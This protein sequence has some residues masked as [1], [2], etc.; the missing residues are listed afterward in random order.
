MRVWLGLLP[1][2]IA[3]TVAEPLDGFSG[4]SA[5]SG[6]I[7]VAV[8]GSGGTS[9]TGGFATAGSSGFPAIECKTASECS[10]G[11]PCNGAEVC[12]PEGKCGPG[13]APKLDDGNAC[14]V[15]FCDPKKG[16]VHEGS[17]GP[18]VKACG[19]PCPK[20]YYVSTA[21][22]CD[23]VCGG[24]ANCGFCVNGWACDEICLPTIQVC[25]RNDACNTVCP[26]GYGFVKETKT[27]KCGCGSAAPGP[28]AEC[29]R[30]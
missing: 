23:T 22:V 28:T 12:L 6:G 19:A 30:K 15:D 20:N 9:G 16:V 26:S 18:T 4:P 29:K 5:G 2:C 1:L 27:E 7:G 10:D 21:L 24:P 17:A 13:T 8:G 3:C 25:C 11:D 14:T